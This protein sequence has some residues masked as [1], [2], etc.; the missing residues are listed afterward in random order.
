MTFPVSEPDTWS[1]EDRASVAAVQKLLAALIS[2]DPRLIAAALTPDAVFTMG[3]IG[4]LPPPARA[5]FA[6][7]LSGITSVEI[8]V[9]KTFAS[10]PVVMMDRTD[11]LV[12][13]DRSI[14]GRWIG[15]FAVKDGRVAEF[16]DYTIE[17]WTTP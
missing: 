4:A 5:N 2:R 12:W 1:A 7:L 11:R 16:T 8:D 3:P 14:V 9:H 10:G 15:I 17:R 13:P 6:A